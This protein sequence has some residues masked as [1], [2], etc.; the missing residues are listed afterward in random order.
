[1]R[2][3]RAEPSLFFEFV[4]GAEPFRLVSCAKI[5]NLQNNNGYWIILWIIG[6]Y[7]SF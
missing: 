3:E 4:E 6:S 1:M 2:L 5:I 7:L